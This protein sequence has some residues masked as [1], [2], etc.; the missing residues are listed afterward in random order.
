MKVLSIFGL[1][2]LISF[3]GSVHPG[4]LNVSVVQTALKYGKKQA[5]MMV[6]GGV[7]PELL[8]GWL[9]VEGVHLFEQNPSL[10][11]WIR[12]SCIVVFIG[13][14]IYSFYTA[15][16]LPALQQPK[17]QHSTTFGKG[18]LLSLF[19]PQLLPFW[20]VVVVSY[21]AYETLAI[22]SISQQASFVCGASIGAFLLNALYVTI[23]FKKRQWLFSYMSPKRFDQCVG[24]GFLSMAM[25]QLYKVWS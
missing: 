11:A 7:L 19:N 12:W 15:G 23:A 21:Q 24:V 6:F 5:Y 8:Y 20:M 1:T 3:L 13:L 4:S 9:A 16:V 18:L 14:G 25:M 10:Y 2:C 17:P 22:H